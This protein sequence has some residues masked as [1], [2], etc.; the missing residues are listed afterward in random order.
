MVG[1]LSE[2][3][4]RQPKRTHKDAEQ[5]RRNSQKQVIDELRRLLPPIALPNDANMN[6]ELDPAIMTSSSPFF[7][8]PTAPLLPGGL[9]PRGPPKAGVDGPNK[10]VSKLQVLLC[11]NEYIKMLK[12]RMERR[13]E[14]IGRLRR[15]IKKLRRKEFDGGGGGGGEVNGEGCEEEEEE[16]VDLDKDLDAV[17]RLTTAAA[18]CSSGNNSGGSGSG[19]AGTLAGAVGD[20]VMDEDEDEDGDD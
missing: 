2:S 19:A 10:N 17:E 11:G 18:K 13:D 3:V 8:H 9:P 12:A 1:G 4:I 7:F 14:E 16:E 6:G 15:E 5:R 20:H